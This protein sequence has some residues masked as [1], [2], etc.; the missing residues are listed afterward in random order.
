MCP[1]LSNT[2]KTKSVAKHKGPLLRRLYV[3][4][5]RPRLSSEITRQLLRLAFFLVGLLPPL[6][7]G[8]IDS[9][10]E[11]LSYQAVHPY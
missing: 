6:H 7:R 9:P 10:P 3:R 8:R 5:L 11:V 1:T 2:P 4:W